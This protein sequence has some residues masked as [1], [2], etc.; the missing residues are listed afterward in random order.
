[1]FVV[2]GATGNTGSVVAN[3]LL[4]AG[5]KVRILVRDATKAQALSARGAEVVVGELSDPAAL[6]RALSGATALYLLSPPDP[7]SEH[8]LAERASMLS[9]AANAAKNANLKHVVFL[10]SVGAQHAEGTGPIRSVHAGEHALRA[11]GLSATFVRAASFVDNWASVL[12]IAEKD[13]VLPSFVP[14]ALTFPMVDTRDIGRT[15]AQALLD[16]P[17]GVRIIELSGPSDVNANDVAQAASKILGRPIKVAEAPLDA[18][19]PTFTSF[20]ISNDMASLFREMYA[21]FRS[22][23]VAFEGGSAEAVRGTLTLE[24]SVRRLLG[25]S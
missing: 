3:A 18:V 24:T 22:G 14:A 9:A 8:F 2:T 11:A 6:G 16:G 10:S 13:G 23:K 25:K 4:D 19:V 12:P 20:G 5:Q 1:M 21:G 7:K 15:A 17:R